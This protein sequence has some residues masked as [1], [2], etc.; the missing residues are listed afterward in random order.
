MGIWCRNPR[1]RRLVWSPR[2]FQNGEGKSPLIGVV[3]PVL[4]LSAERL[5]LSIDESGV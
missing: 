2:L 4:E 5:G 3:L 1:R